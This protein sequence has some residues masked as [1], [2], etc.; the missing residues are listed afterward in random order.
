MAASV[1]WM[2]AAEP[3]LC[4]HQ[5]RELC[6]GSHAR[7]FSQTGRFYQGSHRMM[8]LTKGPVSAPSRLAACADAGDKP[9]GRMLIIEAPEN[10]S[11]P[12][13]A[14]TGR[15][16]VFHGIAAGI[17]LQAIGL[18][19]DG[20]ESVPSTTVELAPCLAPIRAIA[21]LPMRRP[22]KCGLDASRLSYKNKWRSQLAPSPAP[23]LWSRF[24]FHPSCSAY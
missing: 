11:A 4:P 14:E 18:S 15:S 19:V 21:A 16:L 24:H 1:A 23:R 9:T 22:D 5:G 2:S 17:R 20:E 8:T 10:R 7:S 12:T 3:I 6:A 13:E